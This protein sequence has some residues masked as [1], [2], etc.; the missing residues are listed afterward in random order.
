MHGADIQV[1]FFAEDPIIDH[2]SITLCPQ[3]TALTAQ[4]DRI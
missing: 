2:G 3:Q 4:I 1:I